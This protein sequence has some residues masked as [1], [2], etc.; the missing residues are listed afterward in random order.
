VNSAALLAWYREHGR[1][2]LPWRRTRDPYRVLVSEFMLQQTQVE[3]VIP[4]Y[5]AFV[6]AF[7]SFEALAAAESGDAVRLWRGLGYNSRAVRLHALARVVVERHGGT[8]PSDRDALLA[9]P[10][11]GPYTASA[12]RAFAFE[13][14]DVALDTN[15]RRIAHRTEY[16]LEYPP[17]ANDVELD[18]RARVSLL[19]G[20]AHDWNSAMMDVGATICGA[21][22]PKCLICPLRDDCAAAPIDASQLA[23]LAAHQRRK[24]PQESIPFERTTRYLRGRVI[25][26]L[27]DVPRGHTMSVESLVASLAETIP[28]DR[29]GEI[30]SVAES[31]KSD[32]IVAMSEG[33]IR[34]C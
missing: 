29:L 22:A 19:P 34:L 17:R 7:P 26:R 25:D 11:V 27:R 31:L 32:G 24:S 10:G 20:T 14:D 16:G 21:R 18:L 8:L 13:L 28:A 30:G 5:E 3:R 2:H 33:E 9:L 12:I 15:I 1:A 4:L 23:A 6:A